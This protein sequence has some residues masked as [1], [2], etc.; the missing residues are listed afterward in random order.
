MNERDKATIEII[1]AATRPIL[2]GML[3]IGSFVFIVN[4]IFNQWSIAWITLFIVGGG[5]WIFERPVIKI[6]SGLKK[7]DK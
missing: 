7:S 3:L 1:R 4:E 6:L 2:I 5:E